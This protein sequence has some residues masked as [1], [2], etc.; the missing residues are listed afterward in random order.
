MCAPTCCPNP[1]V[2]AGRSGAGGV[3]VLAL[4]VVAGA[5]FAALFGWPTVL[6]CLVAA[7]V[8]TG[9][10]LWGI[11]VLAY[12]VNRALY[13]PDLGSTPNAPH[14]AVRVRATATD[15]PRDRPASPRTVTPRVLTAA[16]VEALTAHRSRNSRRPSL[17]PNRS[18][19]V[20]TAPPG[21]P[22]GPPA[23]LSRHPRVMPMVATWP[24]CLPS[25]GPWPWLALLGLAGAAWLLARLHHAPIGRRA[26]RTRARHRVRRI[27]PASIAGR[28]SRAVAGSPRVGGAR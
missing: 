17:P 25:D 28:S 19:R 15:L 22:V 10:A 4:V 27:E 12:R 26:T 2:V 18:R 13:G 21:R 8:T 24:L 16:E 23:R 20:D 6:L 7:V 14:E 1:G 9:A 11:A 5:V 3:V